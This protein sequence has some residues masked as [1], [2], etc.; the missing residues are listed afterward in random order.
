M[1]LLKKILIVLAIGL[2]P[3]IACDTDALIELNDNPNAVLDLDWRYVLSEAQVSSAENRGVNWKPG[4]IICS[5]LIQHYASSGTNNGDKYI[6]G[7]LT[8]DHQTIPFHDIYDNAMKETGELIRRCGPNGSN[9]EM[10]NTY[11]CARIMY[12][13]L[14]Q[15]ITDFY[16]NVPYFGANRG[17]E[18][19]EF[20]LP[21][22]DPQQEIYTREG[23]GEGE[24]RG[25]LLWE[26]DDAA[27]GLASAGIDNL[28][29][30]DLYFAGDLSKWRKWAYSMMLRAA[31]RIYEED[32]ATAT[33]YINKA[34]AG[35]PMTSNADN[36]W[37]QMASGPSEWFHQ[38]GM[39]RGMRPGSGGEGHE[40]IRPSETLID[41][42]KDNN[43]PRLMMISGGV[44]SWDQCYNDMPECLKDPADQIGR[45]NGWNN[46][47]DD[48]AD[49]QGAGIEFWCTTDPDCS[50][51]WDGVT[52]ID[53]TYFFSLAHPF[54]Y[55]LDEPYFFQTY[56]E[57]E[58]LLA[59]IVERGIATTGSTAQ[60]HYERGVRA[61][62]ERFVTHDAS[63]AVDAA[64]IDAYLL[65]PNI[66]YTSGNAGLEK[67]A[68]QHW[69]ATFM[70]PN[71]WETFAYWRRAGR[72]TLLQVDWFPGQ[73]PP[74]IWRKFIYDQSDVAINGDNFSKGATLPNEETT[75]MWWDQGYDGVGNQTGI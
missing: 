28:A 56:A 12:V 45:P 3:I 27:A 53:P 55:D 46:G 71:H 62:I 47:D 9:P 42:L 54:L 50:A 58:L 11:N 31:M 32:P 44:G 64:V 26:L 29:S 60:Q 2:V 61:A 37:I 57:V 48:P 7:A 66:A 17:V 59:E 51:K 4:Q 63:F 33:T 25:G 14:A 18:G 73:S 15:M 36:C 52:S 35:G 23:I 13:Y 65:E 69:L 74:K 38:N 8:V 21:E 34:I 20:F 19:S 30:A 43:D 16:G 39:S 24:V 6:R 72:P 1:K 5:Q 67:I 22:Y 10:T 70:A 40:Y 49:G 75:Q 41:F 68:W